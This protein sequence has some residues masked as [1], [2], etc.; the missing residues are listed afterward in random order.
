V[1][2]ARKRVGQTF[3]VDHPHA[4]G[5]RGG[6][7]AVVVPTTEPQP[8]SLSIEG[9]ARHEY[10][11][12]GGGIH[13]REVC[14]RFQHSEA[15]ADQ[16]GGVVGVENQMPSRDAGDDPADVWEEVEEEAQVGFVAEGQVGENAGW[17]ME[18]GGWRLGRLV[19]GMA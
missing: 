13:Y 7:K 4:Q 3:V 5:W 12:E 16:A 19:S 17:G 6:E 9:H 1:L 8:S 18:D 11:V 15:V 2:T 14:C 10:Q